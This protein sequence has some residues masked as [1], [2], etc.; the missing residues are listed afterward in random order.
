MYLMYGIK[1]RFEICKMF[2]IVQY[3]GAE[4]GNM[5]SIFQTDPRTITDPCIRRKYLDLI[6]KYHQAI[7][8]DN[9]DFGQFC[10]AKH[11]IK[12][13]SDEPV[14]QKQY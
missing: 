5:C 3:F 8:A 11:L 10:F 12:L 13:K 2:N 6:V 14:F 7:S 4:K 9:Y 1:Y